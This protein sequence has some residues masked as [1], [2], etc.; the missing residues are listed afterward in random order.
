[1]AINI[2]PLKD[3]IVVRPL[4]EETRT[5]GGI[6]LPDT[7]KEKPQQGEVMAVGPGKML[8][9]GERAPVP[10]KAGDKVI[11]GKYAGTEVR[12]EGE[13]FKILELRDVLAKFQ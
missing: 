9:S 2:R 4:E 3:R 11:F 12:V 8:D 6:Y 5:A 7:A 13:E 10:L 1:M